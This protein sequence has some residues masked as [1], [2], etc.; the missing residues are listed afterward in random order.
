VG[1]KS[2]TTEEKQSRNLPIVNLGE[3]CTENISN[4]SN[5][6]KMWRLGLAPPP[7]DRPYVSTHNALNDAYVI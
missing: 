4:L 3:S 2:I 7:L 6:G 5:T 1:I